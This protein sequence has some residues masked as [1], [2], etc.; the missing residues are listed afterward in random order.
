MLLLEHCSLSR[1]DITHKSMII[2]TI[3]N[4]IIELNFSSQHHQLSVTGNNPSQH[5]V[6]SASQPQ[7]SVIVLNFVE[8]YW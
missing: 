1:I 5:P 4:I 3:I 2:R 6:E 8:I 7:A